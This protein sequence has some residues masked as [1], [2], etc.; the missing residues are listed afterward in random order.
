MDKEET[1]GGRLR[2]ERLRLEFGQE[3]FA[4]IAGATRQ[5]QVNWEKGVGSPNAEAIAAWAQHGLDITYLVTGERAI[6][7]AATPYEAELLRQAVADVGA[8]ASE[9]EAPGAAV[10]R[11]YNELYRQAVAQGIHPG[12]PISPKE[13]VLLKSYREAGE[14]GK[15]VIERMAMLEAERGPERP[16]EV[17]KVK[18]R[19]DDNMIV[20][21]DVTV[22]KITRGGTRKK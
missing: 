17:S 20:R 13:E 7:K 6:N 18:V 2:E 5:T 22:G 16:T 8:R 21:G 15:R 14:Q 1:L 11:R 3:A 12:V 9:I 4:Q 10:H 19:G